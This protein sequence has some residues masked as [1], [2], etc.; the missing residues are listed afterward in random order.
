[1]IDF[2]VPYLL[3]VIYNLP[4]NDINLFNTLYL[5]VLICTLDT[6]FYYSP[7]ET[8]NAFDMHHFDHK[9]ICLFAAVYAGIHR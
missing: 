1:M 7:A 8:A 9:P 6:A 2:A 4:L 5:F 3:Q